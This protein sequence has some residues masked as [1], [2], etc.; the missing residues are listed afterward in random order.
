MH[1][2]TVALCILALFPGQ[3]KKLIWPVIH[4]SRMHTI[5][6]KTWESVHVYRREP[7]YFHGI[8]YTCANSVYQAVFSNGLGTTLYV[9]KVLCGL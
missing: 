2:A 4:F 9:C 8:L 7:D 3:L 6:I 5:P 1:N